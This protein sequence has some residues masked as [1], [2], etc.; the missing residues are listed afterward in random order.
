MNL[1]QKLS[2]K[3]KKSG[4]FTLIEMLIVVAIIAILIA[5]SIPLVSGALEKART[6]TDAANERAAKAAAVIAF[7][8]EDKIDD[9]AFA[10]GT[11]YYYDAANGVLTSD[12]D[13]LTYGQCSDHK[14]GYISVKV[15]DDGTVLLGWSTDTPNNE[16]LDSTELMT[17]GDSSGSTGD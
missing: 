15:N 16:N 3:L 6:A 13:G 17:G 14:D 9:T 2:K 11:T 4:G 12:H 1:K 10:T 5:V 8:T 7:L